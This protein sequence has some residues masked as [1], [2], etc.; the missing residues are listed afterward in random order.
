M[1]AKRALFSWRNWTLVLLQTLAL[2]GSFAFL[3]ESVASPDGDH[4]ARRMDLGQY[5]PTV[6]PFSV[7]GNSSL[8]PIFLRHLRGALGSDRHTLK[9]VQGE[10][11]QGTSDA[12]R[13]EVGSCDCTR[14]ALAD[15]A[16]T[17]PVIPCRAPAFSRQLSE[18]REGPAL[19]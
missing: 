2:L 17:A 6:V 5:G 18:S 7:S 13:T 16:A 15:R 14:G 4:E 9:E 10:A 1:L 8:T 11:R 19:A 12:G 3:T